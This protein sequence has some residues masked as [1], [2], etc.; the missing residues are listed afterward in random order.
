MADPAAQAEAQLKNIEESTGKTVSQFATLIQ[1]AGLEKH[2]QMVSHLK[3]ELGLTHGNANLIA[4]KVRELLA[5]GPP[6]ENDL[7]E[8][9]YEG[10]KADL[11]PIFDRLAAVAGGQGKDVERVVQKAGVSFRRKKQFALIQAPSAKRIQLGLNLPT[12]PDDDRVAEVSGM[13]SHRVNVTALEQIDR[14]IEEWIEA[15]YKSAG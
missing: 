12:T 11:R 13:C 2:G 4:H 7:L 10:A 1:K 14:T 15:S 6:P 8:A 3:S 9:Q 5:G